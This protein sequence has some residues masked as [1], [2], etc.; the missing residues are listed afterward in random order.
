MPS[1]PTPEI[2]AAGEGTELKGAGTGAG[3]GGGYPGGA[4]ACLGML[5]FGSPSGMDAP[6]RSASFRRIPGARVRAG[7]V[8]RFIHSMN[9]G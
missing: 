4:A 7:G 2:F 6:L 5:A 9:K 1:D 3:R 8:N